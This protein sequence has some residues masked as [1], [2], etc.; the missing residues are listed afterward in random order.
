M[1]EMD[2]HARALEE[3]SVTYER[4][5]GPGRVRCARC[6]DAAKLSRLFARTVVPRA[7]PL[8]SA[9]WMDRGHLLVLDDGEAILAAALVE[10]CD[11][12]GHLEFLVI[13]PTVTSSG[14]EDRMIGVAA[15]LCEAYEQ[16]T[17]EIASTP[18]VPARPRGR[19]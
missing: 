11:G 6:D 10:N 9:H 4:R 16:E 14:V 17:M 7:L 8:D 2:H 15:A 13:D 5:T 18:A 12:R 19:R 1:M 3:D